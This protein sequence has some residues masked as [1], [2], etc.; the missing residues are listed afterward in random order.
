[1]VDT[2]MENTSYKNKIQAALDLT[3]MLAEMHVNKHLKGKSLSQESIREIRKQWYLD[4]LR[5]SLGDTD[6]VLSKRV[7]K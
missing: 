4:R 7:I 6:G 5:I 3:E 1:M 2:T